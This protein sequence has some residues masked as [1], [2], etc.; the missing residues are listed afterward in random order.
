MILILNLANLKKSL[1]NEKYML[2]W[3]QQKVDDSR[4]NRTENAHGNQLQ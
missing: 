3:N 1:Q 4:N 2:Q